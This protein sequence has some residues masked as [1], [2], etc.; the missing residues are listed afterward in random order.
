MSY[1]LEE[2]YE[3]GASC[4]TLF[5]QGSQS[6]L[7]TM[8]YASERPIVQ[9][10]SVGDITANIMGSGRDVGGRTINDESK[11]GMWYV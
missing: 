3:I 2:S 7:Y 8:S 4:T 9:Q 11:V 10:Q 6:A 1:C 5:A